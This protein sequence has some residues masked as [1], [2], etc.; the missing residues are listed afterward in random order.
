MRKAIALVIAALAF[1]FNPLFA[2]DSLPLSPDWDYGEKDMR[3]A[4]E[5]TFEL[6][7]QP[8]DRGP[9]TKLAFQIKQKRAAKQRH[10][11]SSWIS[12]ANAC[13]SRDF[14]ATAGACIDDSFMEVEFVAVRG[15]LVPTD[16]RFRV[17]GTRFVEGELMFNLPN[18]TSVNAHIGRDGT[19]RN[20]SMSRDGR[21]AMVRT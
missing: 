1:V 10:A 11:A 6:S 16:G 19:I 21:V 3:T 12:T 14:I 9:G 17:F 18:G 7:V 8:V 20:V 15:G 13:T 2:C 4:V 5:G